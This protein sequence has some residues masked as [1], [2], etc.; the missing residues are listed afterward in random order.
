MAN[1][2]EQ[3]QSVSQAGLGGRSIVALSLAEPIDSLAGDGGGQ[4]V[5][6]SLF[7]LAERQDGQAARRDGAVLDD[8]VLCLIITF[9]VALLESRPEGAA[10]CQPRA[11]PWESDRVLRIATP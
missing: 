3:R 5:D 6:L 7:V 4:E 2:Q 11:P 10:T 1:G 8:A 9:A